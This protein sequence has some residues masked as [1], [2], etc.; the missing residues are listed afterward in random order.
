[1]VQTTHYGNYEPPH[2]WGDRPDE[3]PLAAAVWDEAKTGDIKST[4][5]VKALYEAVKELEA[6][7]IRSEQR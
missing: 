6:R 1:M 4:F 5:V 2:P 7:V 3:L